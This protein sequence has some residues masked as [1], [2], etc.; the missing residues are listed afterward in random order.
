MTITLSLCFRRRSTR[1]LPTKPTPPVKN[2][3]RPL[4]S[5][6][7]AAD[8]V[9]RVIGERKSRRGGLRSGSRVAANMVGLGMGLDQVSGDCGEICFL[10]FL[11][12]LVA[13]IGPSRRTAWLLAWAPG[14]TEGLRNNSLGEPGLIINIMCVYIYTWWMEYNYIFF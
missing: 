4:R 14:K 7:L 12:R 2:T 13:R 10:F 11:H 6:H 9:P 1:W 5:R 8:E 3:R